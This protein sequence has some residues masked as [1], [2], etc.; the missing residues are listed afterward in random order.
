MTVVIPSDAVEAEAAVKAAYDH[1]GP[2]YIVLVA[3]CPCVQHFELG[4]GIVLKEGTD[5]T[6]RY[7]RVLWFPVALEVAEQLA[8]EV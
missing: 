1:D 6:L 7:C 4:K 5:V 8:A 2:V 3:C